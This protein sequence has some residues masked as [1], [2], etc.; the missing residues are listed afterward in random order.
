MENAFLQNLDI[1]DP[2]AINTVRMFLLSG[3]F[4]KSVW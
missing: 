2:A 4:L 1:I 3:H